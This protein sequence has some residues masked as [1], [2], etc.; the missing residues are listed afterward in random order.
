[1]VLPKPVEKPADAPKPADTV[2]T[3]KPADKPVEKKEPEKETAPAV[4]T[5]EVLNAT[6]KG[7]KDPTANLGKDD[8]Q[9]TQTFKLDK[10]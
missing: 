2:V 8:D 4:E 3:P 9:P 7:S 5:G 1:V 6:E 10:V